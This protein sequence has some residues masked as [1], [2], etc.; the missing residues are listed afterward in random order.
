MSTNENVKNSD[1]TKL[2]DLK[3]G[4]GFLMEVAVGDHIAEQ[5]LKESSSN[6]KS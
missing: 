4:Q 2:S 3:P 1:A 5:Q 6:N